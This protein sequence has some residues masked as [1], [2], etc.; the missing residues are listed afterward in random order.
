MRYDMTEIEK[1][2]AAII[3]SRPIGN[4]DPD[5]DPTGFRFLHADDA[6]IVHCFFREP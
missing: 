6:P 3:Y 2:H 5:V 1:Y 4:A